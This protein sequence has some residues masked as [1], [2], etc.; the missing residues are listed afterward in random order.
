MI[1]YHTR[2]GRTGIEAS[3]KIVDPANEPSNRLIERLT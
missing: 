3:R 1:I 2:S